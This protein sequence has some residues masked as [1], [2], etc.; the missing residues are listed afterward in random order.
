VFCFFCIDTSVS[1]SGLSMPT[2]IVK[3]FAALISANRASSSAMLIDASVE[4]SNG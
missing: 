4:N 2:K 3:K 1:V